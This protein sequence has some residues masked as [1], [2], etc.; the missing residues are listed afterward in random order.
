MKYFIKTLMGL[1]VATAFFI[2]FSSYAK[3]DAFL[4]VPHI[5]Q[6]TPVW[7][8]VAAAQQVIA[9]KKGFAGTPRQCALVEAIDGASAGMCCNAGHPGCVHT[10][11]FKQ[12][13]MLISYFGGSYSTYVLPANAYII[14]Q[15]LQAGRPILAQIATGGSSTHVVVIRGIRMTPTPVL[16]IN[17]PMAPTPYETPFINLA[18]IWI[19]GIVI[20]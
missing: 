6:L 7:C 3:A 4:N 2:S 19:D 20:D 18:T 12:V 14:E 13:A 15:T 16:L 10:G 9:Y 17:D 5:Q 1:A 11:D 8:W